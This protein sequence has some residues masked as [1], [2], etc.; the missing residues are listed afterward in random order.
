MKEG[1]AINFA[2]CGLLSCTGVAG[3]DG[4]FTKFQTG[5]AGRENVL[6]AVMW[7]QNYATSVSPI[8]LTCH[9]TINTK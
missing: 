3:S 6:L 5:I 7:W 8:E 1:I 2:L 4:K 9:F